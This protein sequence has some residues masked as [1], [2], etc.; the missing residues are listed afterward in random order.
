MPRRMG[1]DA[2]PNATP[3]RFRWRPVLLT[4]SVLAV[5]TFRFLGDGG[6]GLV[7]VV[8]TTLAL[9]VPLWWTRSLGLARHRALSRKHPSDD[10]VEVIGARNLRA[11]L[12]KSGV[13]EPEG[14][15]WWNKS[16]SRRSSPTRA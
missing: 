16:R 13:L 8:G 9:V 5:V 12:V 10:V 15:R 7:W 11:T 14:L 4:S 2:D 1:P 6:S 3:A